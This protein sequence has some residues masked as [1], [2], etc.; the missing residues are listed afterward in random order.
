MEQSVIDRIITEVPR[1]FHMSGSLSQAVLRR[2]AQLHTE[3]GA[4]VS[5]ETGCGLTT[6]IL[7]HLSQRHTVFTVDFGDSLPNTR[8]HSLFNSPTT[9]FV[10]NPTQIS[11]PRHEFKGEL[12]FVII[13]GPHGYPFPDLE[14]FYFYP[15][16]R[17]GGILVV[18]DVHI[19]TIGHL[20]DFLCD[21]SMW[22][23]LGDVETTAFFK[24]T[25]APV[26]D[27]H[28]DGWTSQRYNRRYFS[29][30]QALD[31]EFGAGW[32]E[33]DFSS[34]TPSKPDGSKFV[35]AS[36]VERLLDE[37]EALEQD[38]AQTRA[39]LQRE[40]DLHGNVQALQ[41]QLEQATAAVDA[42]RASTSWRIT[43]PLRALRGLVK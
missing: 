23:H 15:R 39:M 25:N 22:E 24:R 13:D 40:R 38:L 30:P 37:R 35:H 28:G 29:Y 11:L 17:T 1:D 16:V 12:D 26:L 32:Y 6:L 42:L 18:D 20:Y 9:D 31:A 41:H 21:D 34:A 43:A 4:K 5:A 36:V 33:R 27:P 8:N 2:I 19:P 7:S 14:Y 10:V 3:V